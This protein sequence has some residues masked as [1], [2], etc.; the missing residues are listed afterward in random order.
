M[1][2]NDNNVERSARRHRPAIIGIL[3]ALALAAMAFFLF[4][5][6]QSDEHAVTPA[7]GVAVGTATSDAPAVSPEGAAPTP[8][9]P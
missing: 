3:V 9:K 1:S 5:P 4:V 7:G 6:W 2:Y 8:A